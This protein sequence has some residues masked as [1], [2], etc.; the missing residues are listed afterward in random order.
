MKTSTIIAKLIC[1]SAKN[2]IPVNFISDNAPQFSSEEFTEFANDWDFSLIKMSPKHSQSNGMVE[3]NGGY[4]QENLREGKIGRKRSIFGPIGVPYNSHKT[5]IF[6][7][8]I[9][10]GEKIKTYI[11][12][13][14]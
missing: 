8:S 3:K 13:D 10:H 6:S 2:G 9:T 1:T 7:Q 4:L 11:A 12:S 14:P 5:W